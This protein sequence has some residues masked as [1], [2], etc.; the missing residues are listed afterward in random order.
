MDIQDSFAVDSPGQSQDEWRILS[1]MAAGIHAELLN[2][3]LLLD[4]PPAVGL[5]VKKL[6]ESCPA[7]LHREF[8]VVMHG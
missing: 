8:A 7:P 2:N 4:L 1:C 6:F 5:G 3:L